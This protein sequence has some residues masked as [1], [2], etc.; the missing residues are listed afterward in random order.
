MRLEKTADGRAPP[1]QRER[2]NV[3]GGGGLLVA[4]G[5]IGGID[6]VDTEEDEASEACEV[7]HISR[8]C[9]DRCNRCQC[10]HPH[11]PTKHRYQLSLLDQ[12]LSNAPSAGKDSLLI[13]V[14][15]LAVCLCKPL[16]QSV[17]RKAK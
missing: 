2:R 10:A 16:Y 11:L 5:R 17:C 4:H 1:K 7:H 8:V 9:C 3:E 15:L 13:V 6:V 12:N 14:A